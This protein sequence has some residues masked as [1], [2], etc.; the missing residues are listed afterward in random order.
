MLE[1]QG[2]IAPQILSLRTKQHVRADNSG[3]HHRNEAAPP[4]QVKNQ[5]QASCKPLQSDV[6]EFDH[7]RG[8]LQDQKHGYIWSYRSRP[9]R[10][11]CTWMAING[12]MI[13]FRTSLHPGSVAPVYVKLP[14]YRIHVGKAAQK[15]RAN[16]FETA[17]YIRSKRKCMTPPWQTIWHW[18]LDRG[19]GGNVV[20]VVITIFILE[21]IR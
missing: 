8:Q 1:W 20:V 19:W 13:E 5:W 7:D 10:L 17:G 12:C 21:A 15:H 4:G 2:S 16:I 11:V 14:A 3:L 18:Q 6:T 9:A